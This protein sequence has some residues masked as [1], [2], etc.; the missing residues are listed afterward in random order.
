V[1]MDVF[2]PQGEHAVSWIYRKLTYLTGGEDTGRVAGS[3][4]HAPLVLPDSR[5]QAS[6]RLR[7]GPRR[8]LPLLPQRPGVITESEAIQPIRGRRSFGPAS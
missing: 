7:P 3:G 5:S 2:V 8:R 1:A 4:S 6:W